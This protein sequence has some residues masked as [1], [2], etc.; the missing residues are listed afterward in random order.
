MPGTTGVSSNRSSAAAVLITMG[1]FPTVAAIQRPSIVVLLIAVL[2]VGG[3]LY[4]GFKK[5]MV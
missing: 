2:M 5:R 1:L 3:G 4:L